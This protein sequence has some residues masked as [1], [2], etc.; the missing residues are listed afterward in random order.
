MKLKMFLFIFLL[1]LT[2][3]MG[4]WDFVVGGRG[5][6]QVGGNLPKYIY[7]YPGPD[8]GLGKLD[9][10]P[11]ASTNRWPLQPEGLHNLGAST[12]RGPPHMSYHLLFF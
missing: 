12:T 8:L 9:S 1:C 4:I 2:A 6:G 7:I 10:W 3:S 11:G 5:G